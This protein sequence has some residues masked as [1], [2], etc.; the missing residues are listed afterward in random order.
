[1]AATASAA[2]TFST[3]VLLKVNQTNRISVVATNSSGTSSTAAVVTVVHDD[4]PPEVD[5]DVGRYAGADPFPFTGTTEA[6]A[7]VT[8]TSAIDTAQT[9]ADTNGRFQQ[10][11]HLIPEEFNELTRRQIPSN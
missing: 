11:I 6:G 1:M 3:S 10:E 4:I 7:E 2:G 8:L 5:A 9:T